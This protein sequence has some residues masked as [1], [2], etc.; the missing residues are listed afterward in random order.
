MKS[1]TAAQILAHAK[2]V[3][4]RPGQRCWTCSLPPDLLKSI[5]QARAAG[6]EIGGIVSYMTE[7]LGYKR[8]EAA[9]IKNH[10]IARHHDR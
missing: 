9:R 2:S 5:H 8:T 3:R 1:A 4:K 7:K 10:F 6:A